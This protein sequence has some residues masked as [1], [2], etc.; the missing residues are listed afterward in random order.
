MANVVFLSTSLRAGETTSEK[1][2]AHK[3]AGGTETQQY[4]VPTGSDLSNGS[5]NATYG[6]NRIDAAGQ[7][8]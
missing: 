3:A 1:L 6:G 8:S 5:E 4:P 2:A 7:L